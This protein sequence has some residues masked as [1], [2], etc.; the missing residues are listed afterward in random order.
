[1]KKKL[2]FVLVLTVFVALLTG[3]LISCDFLSTGTSDYTINFYSDT[4][5][6]HSVT[7]TSETTTVTMPAAPTKTG[8]V[9]DDWYY[10]KDVWEQPFTLQSISGGISSNIKIYAHFL[11]QVTVTY[12]NGTSTY[13]TFSAVEGDALPAPDGHP[14]QTGYTFSEWVYPDGISLPPETVGKEN[15]T[16]IAKYV[17]NFYQIFL[18]IAFGEFVPSSEDIDILLDYEHGYYIRVEFDQPYAALLDSID[19][20]AS[21]ELFAYWKTQDGVQYSPSSVYNVA[22]NTYLEPSWA[23]PGTSGVIYEQISSGV[24]ADTYKAIGYNGSATDVVIAMIYNGKAV[25]CIAFAGTGNE[26]LIETLVMQNSIQNIGSGAFSSCANLETVIIPSSVAFIGANAFPASA[27]IDI[28]CL[29]PIDSIPLVWGSGWACG[30]IAIYNLSTYVDLFFDLSTTEDLL[31]DQSLFDVVSVNVLGAG[32]IPVSAPVGA[33]ITGK[34]VTLSGEDLA[35][36][37][38][39]VYTVVLVGDYVTASFTL[40]LGYSGSFMYNKNAGGD[41][42]LRYNPVQNLS[43]VY[44]G[45]ITETGYVIDT[46]EDRLSFESNYLMSLKGGE[47]EYLLVFADGSSEVITGTVYDSD[48]APYNVKLD[49][50]RNAP[51]YTIL[52]DCDYNGST[53]YSYKIDGG[54]YLSCQSGDTVTAQSKSSAHTLYVR[55]NGTGKV[56]TYILPALTSALSYL[57]D[58]FTYNGNSYDSFIADQ[59]E[60]NVAMAYLAQQSLDSGALLLDDPQKPFGYVSM[61]VYI[62]ESYVFD[63][64]SLTE[65]AQ[66]F[67]FSYNYSYGHARLGQAVTLNFTLRCDQGQSYVTGSLND[68]LTDGSSL[69]ALTTPETSLPIDSL[70][71]TELI[72]SVYEL[73]NLPYGIKPTFVTGSDAELIYEAAREICGLYIDND[74][75]DAEKVTIIYEWLAIN[76]TYDYNALDVMELQNNVNAAGSLNSARSLITNALGTQAWDSALE[77]ALLIAR[78][79]ASDVEELRDAVDGIVKSLACFSLNG[80]FDN[81]SRRIAVC[82]GYASA[83]K[84][85]CLIEGIECVEVSGWAGENHAWN[86]VQLGGDWY[87]VDSTWAR[88]GATGEKIM[89]HQWLLVSDSTALTGSNP[90]IEKNNAYD[91]CVAVLATVEYNYYQENGLV[92]TTQSALNTLFQTGYANADKYIEFVFAIDGT[93]AGDAISAAIISLGGGS[94]SFSTPQNDKNVYTVDISN[95]M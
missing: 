22:G 8:Y 46:I 10:D 27:S 54:S 26:N 86:K 74:L 58:T 13:T 70:I 78:N 21:G 39:G 41:L 6:H 25:S 9:F 55:C 48:A 23:L 82:D 40:T 85:M 32:G 37:E 63:S 19:L 95:I 2:L 84:L 67:S 34:L 31:V 66:S 30:N 59:S 72:K 47:Y 20:S 94:Y 36:Q 89:T 52:F 68:P 79:D 28:F 38:A 60:L 24:Y 77:S 50:D 33:D 80:I 71:V 7:I 90:H 35:A 57:S 4:T 93:T 69:T 44:G 15:L 73:D 14:E 75:T 43:A 64:G 81:A 87:V 11:K 18:G 76:V 92:I 45:G 16:F 29:I 88:S 61:P 49:M 65:A 53:T 42:E 91:A 3:G 51:I 56:G 62:S 5:L 12:T 17:P 1:M 83:F